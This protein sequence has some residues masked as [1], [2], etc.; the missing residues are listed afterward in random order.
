MS[1]NGA[2]EYV[3]EPQK[4]VPVAYDVDVAVVGSGIGGLF[5]A[6]AAGKQGAK[7]LV[8]DRMAALGGNIGPAMIVAGGLYNEADGTLVGGL[9]GIPK[10]VI[11]MVEERRT[12]NN[13]ADETSLVSYLGAKLS[14]KWGIELLLTVWAG[15]PIMEG[16]RVTGLFVEGKSGRMAVKAKVV[17][18]ATADVDIARRA[19]APVIMASPPD[20][21]HGPLVRE[22]RGGEPYRVWNDTA[23]F[24]MVAGVDFAAY[25]AFAATRVPLSAADREWV[26]GR[27]PGS[28]PQPL[29]PLLR[30]AWEDGSF[31]HMRDL[32]PTVHTE[33][34]AISQ[35]DGHVGSSRLNVRGEI[36]REDMKQHSKIE[37][38]AR[39][40]AQETLH[41]YREHVPGFEKAYMLFMVPYFG[42]RGGPCID[43]ERT[44][45]A[46]EAYEGK[47]F[48][49]VMYRNIHEGQDMHGGEKSGHDAPYRMIQPKEVEGLLVTGRGAAYIRRGHDPTGMRARPSIMALGEATGIA[50]ALSTKLGVTPKQLD[51]KTL[52]RELLRQGAYL[53]DEARLAELGLR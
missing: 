53:G 6:L 3:V 51:V 21:A 35:F 46:M 41:F 4:R 34:A 38:A 28:F 18:D 27:N 10:M 40:H 45:T 13:Y 29:L 12:A 9:S 23:L 17:I 24:Y 19:G 37:T 2:V 14:E 25:E 31:R 16:N 26:R 39:V 1:E 8:I 20:P 30:R 7:T 49:D 11:D 48:R 43:G 42:A 50:A 52:Q 32:E 33:S 5:A 44:V 36:R 47:K 15:D 22:R